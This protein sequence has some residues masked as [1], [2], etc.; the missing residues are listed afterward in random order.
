MDGGK[1]TIK[2]GCLGAE[3]YGSG[4]ELRELGVILGGAGGLSKKL[5]ARGLEVAPTPDL[6]GVRG[7]GG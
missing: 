5:G 7:L 6:P 2:L 1:G 4:A 3:G